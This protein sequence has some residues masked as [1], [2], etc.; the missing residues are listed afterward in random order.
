MRKA[1]KQSA[2]K[3]LSPGQAA[4]VLERLIK[5][6]RVTQGDVNR[7]VSEMTHEISELEARLQKLRSVIAGAVSTVTRR[8][9]PAR[10]EAAPAPA[11][12]KAAKAAPRTR[13][14]NSVSP[15]RL[16]SRKLQGR[17]LAL[18]RQ[19]PANKRP[20]YAKVAKERGREAAIKEMQAAVGK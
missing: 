19:I 16:A 7:Y 13:R 10:A 4:Y 3:Q 2:G 17:Y 6:R 12:R 18:I 1:K 15:E 5:D 20:Q 9:R 8:G 14:R 11:G